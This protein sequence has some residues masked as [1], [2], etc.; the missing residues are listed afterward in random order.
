MTELFPVT[1]GV[2]VGLVLYRCTPKLLL[3]MLVVLSMVLGLTASA[4]SGELALGLGFIPVDVA[5]VLGVG[6]VTLAL[7]A[8]WERRALHLR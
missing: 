3:P 6:L 4:I 5:E 7:A 1:A 8:L 2:I